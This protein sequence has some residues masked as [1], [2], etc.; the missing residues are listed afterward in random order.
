MKD[1]ALI[2]KFMGFWPTE[3]AL[4]AW[5]AAKWKPKGHINL[6]LEPKGFFTTIFN[7]IQDRNMVLDNNPYF[8]NATELYLRDCIERF[9]SDKEDLSS[10]PVWIWLYSLPLEYLVEESLK[11]IDNGLGEFMKVAK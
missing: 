6:K 1:H 8:I 4:Q 2:G 7:C 10:T 3:K 5:I 9:N 11:D